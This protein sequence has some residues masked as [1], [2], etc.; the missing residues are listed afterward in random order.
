MSPWLMILYMTN[1]MAGNIIFKG[2]GYIKT[3][4]PSENYDLTLSAANL[5]DVVVDDNLVASG[6]IS[7]EN[8]N[9]LKLYELSTN[10]TS[11]IS[12]LATSS[13]TS[14]L[15]FYLPA[16]DGTAGYALTTNGNGDLYW[17]TPSGSGSVG[18]ATLI[19]QVPY[20]A[21]ASNSL[22]ATSSLFIHSLTAE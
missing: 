15:T 10:G 7:I 17:S 6:N 18:S 21:A 22:T 9:A 20:Y 3:E 16:A 1:S 12:L 11:S 2:L 4:S 5:G 19:G 13:M 8:N 14:D